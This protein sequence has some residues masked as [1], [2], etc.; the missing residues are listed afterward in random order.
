MKIA[1]ATI[2]PDARQKALLKVAWPTWE[3]YARR[4]SLEI[5]VVERPPRPEHIYWGKYAYFGLDEF[6]AVDAIVAVDN[7]MLFNPNSPLVTDGWDG[8]RIGMV[9]ER[10]QFGWDEAYVER[11]YRSYELQPPPPPAG[12]WAVL[13]GGLILYTRDHIP[14]FERTY[15]DWNEWRGRASAEAIQANPF[16]YTNDQPHLSLAV[17]IDNQAQILDPNFNRIWWSWLGK[18]GRLPRRAFQFYAKGCSML[19]AALPASFVSP[20]AR[21]GARVLERAL[22]ECHFLHIAGSKSPMWLYAHRRDD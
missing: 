6:S 4:H 12:T 19:G 16:K 9:D 15:R 18:Y 3:R 8:K 5:I 21:P 14:F 22:S 1:I 11:Y 13:N 17:Q 7:D 2:A 20:L 10:A